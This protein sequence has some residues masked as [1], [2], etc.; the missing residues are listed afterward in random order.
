M[1]QYWLEDGRSHMQS[2]V[3]FRNDPQLTASKKMGVLD[4]KLQRNEFCQYPVNSEVDPYP[5]TSM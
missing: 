3:T 5:I 4:L 1:C 2:R